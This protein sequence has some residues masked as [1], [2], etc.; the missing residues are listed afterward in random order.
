MALSMAYRPTILPEDPPSPE[1]I[2]DHL[3]RAGMSQLAFAVWCGS[4]PQAVRKWLTDRE[5]SSHR[6]PPRMLWFALW[7]AVEH[8]E[9]TGQEG[10]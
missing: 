2:R 9:H 3:A 10:R 6:D 4:T 7:A 8:A 5:N 1:E